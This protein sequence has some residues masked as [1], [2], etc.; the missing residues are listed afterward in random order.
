VDVEDLQTLRWANH[1][2][3]SRLDVLLNRGPLRNAGCGWLIARWVPA[4]YEHLSKTAFRNSP[5]WFLPERIFRHVDGYQLA[6]VNPRNYLLI[7][8]VKD[9]R[10][11]LRGV[12]LFN[13]FFSP[14]S[15]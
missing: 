14:D 9:L 12:V 4:C 6:R 8:H 2:G 13:H 11:L 1:L 10:N 7:V 15:K 3:V 5:S